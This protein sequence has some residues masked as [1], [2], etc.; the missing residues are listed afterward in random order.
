MRRRDGEQQSL[1]GLALARRIAARYA[2]LPPVTAVALG[3]SLAT[4][5]AIAD[6]DVDLYVYTTEPIPLPARATIA[7]P[8]DPHREVDL[9]PWEPGDTWRDTATGR[10][11]DVMFRAPSWIERQLDHVLVDHQAAVGYST[12]LWHNVLTS[13]PLFDRDDWFAALQRRADRPYSEE[14]RRAIVAANY[15]LLRDRSF[16]FLRQIEAAVARND[17]IAVQH[18]LTAFLASLFDV[19][20]ALNRRPHPGDKRLVVQAMADCTELPPQFAPRLDA[21]LEAARLGSVGTL[22]DQA[23]ALIDDVDRLLPTTDSLG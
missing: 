10:Q 5:L 22:V 8:D 19:L 1:E 15:P 20:F 11:V 6:S 18:R 4:G 23:N 2:A 21:L 17:A 14:L 16:S 7:D 13:S 3:G 9:S 12:A